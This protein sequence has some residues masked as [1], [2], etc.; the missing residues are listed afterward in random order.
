MKPGRRFT[1]DGIV[2]Y[3]FLV[4]PL[5]TLCKAEDGSLTQWATHELKAILSAESED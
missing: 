5:T 1:Q 2:Y 3:V 4:G